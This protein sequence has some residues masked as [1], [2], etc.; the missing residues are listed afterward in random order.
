M[1]LSSVCIESYTNVIFSAHFEA[2]Y[3]RTILIEYGNLIC[4]CKYVAGVVLCLFCGL[5]IS[6]LMI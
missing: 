5:R 2:S 4:V 3:Q 1:Y 6:A